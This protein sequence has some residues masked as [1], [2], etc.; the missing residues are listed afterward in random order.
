MLL[1]SHVWRFCLPGGRDQMRDL[2]DWKSAVSA[3]L[4]LMGAPLEPTLSS[5]LS[6]CFNLIEAAAGFKIV[7]F[8]LLLHFVFFFCF[9]YFY[10][11]LLVVCVI[12]LLIKFLAVCFCFSTFFCFQFLFLKLV[13]ESE[14]LDIIF[15]VATTD[16]VS[17]YIYMDL[18]FRIVFLFPYEI[19][20]WIGVFAFM[21]YQLVKAWLKC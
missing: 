8:S 5:V 11:V 4:F 18:F 10:F 13:F 12:L 14:C 2:S 1:I 7:F 21:A 20:I 19:G 17:I 9:Y 15:E 3:L 16:I 6:L